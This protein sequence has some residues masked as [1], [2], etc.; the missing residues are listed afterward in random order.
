MND[1]IKKTFY[2]MWQDIK[3]MKFAIAAI[4]MYFI[5]LK[6][7]FYSTC[8][9]V[10]LTGIPCPAC[11]M[12]R[13][14]FSI[15]KGNFYT[16]WELNPFIYILIVFLFFYGLNRYFLHKSYRILKKLTIAAL[17][18]FL[19]FY[20]WR[21][22]RFFPDTWPMQYYPDNLYAHFSQIVHRIFV[23]CGFAQ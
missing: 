8:P 18:A 21:M 20:I 11:G 9:L 6:H 1:I 3:D 19:I 17:I 5:L 7:F 13:A 23:V 12:T 22:Y 4:L 14:G 2:L 15:L 16:A 10:I